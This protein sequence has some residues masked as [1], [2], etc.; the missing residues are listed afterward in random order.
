M[1]TELSTSKSNIV[2]TE[3]SEIAQLRTKVFELEAQM[4]QANTMIQS[5]THTLLLQQQRDDLS[6]SLGLV[7]S[8]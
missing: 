1:S 2:T 8:T 4:T 7:L 5:L 6:Q 3:G